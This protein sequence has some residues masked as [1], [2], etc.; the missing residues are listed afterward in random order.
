M[1]SLASLGMTRGWGL[2]VLS[3]REVSHLKAPFKA[4]LPVPGAIVSA[5]ALKGGLRCAEVWSSHCWSA[6]GRWR[7]S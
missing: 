3:A 2:A 7:E 4:R 5:R 6:R 1:R